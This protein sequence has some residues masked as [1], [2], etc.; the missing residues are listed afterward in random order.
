MSRKKTRNN[1]KDHPLANELV[2]RGHVPEDRRDAVAA[3]LAARARF[4]GRFGGSGSAVQDSL[5]NLRRRAEALG[6]A[7]SQAARA[8]ERYRQLMEEDVLPDV[9][10]ILEEGPELG[11][12][13]EAAERL[14]ASGTLPDVGRVAREAGRQAKAHECLRDLLVQVKDQLD[15]TGPAGSGRRG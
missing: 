9:R 4:L 8:M 2:A 3:Y 11:R 15:G 5:E 14:W 1:N 6:E 10:L 12:I 7:A 13:E